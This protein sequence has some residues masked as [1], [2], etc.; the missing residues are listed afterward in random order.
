MYDIGSPWAG[1]T[2]VKDSTGALANATAVVLT[3]TLPDLTTVT[4]AVSNPTTGNY[5][6]TYP[7]TQAGR[8]LVNWVATG[9]NAS[10]YSDVFDVRSAAINSIVS[11]ADVKD[12]LNIPQA[13]TTQDAELRGFIGSATHVIE[14][15]V[16][17]CAQR[18]VTDLYTGSW[19]QP[20]IVLLTQPVISVTTVTENSLTLA[21]G[22][23]YVLLN[24]GGT[25]ARTIGGGGTLYERGYWYGVNDIS[26]TYIAGR[27]IIPSNIIEAAMEWARIRFRPQ[28]GGD[29]DLFDNDGNPTGSQPFGL[30][31]PPSV[32]DLLIPHADVASGIA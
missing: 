14:H 19:A 25:L 20:E 5:T 3:I 11:L 26:V 29:V 12:Y 24:P 4:P 13:D 27:R 16:G 28:R 2:T 22:I 7:T 6:A 31:M 18:T 1:A 21:Q 23:D 9:T 17:A 32:R 15:E 10:T 30:T 8:H